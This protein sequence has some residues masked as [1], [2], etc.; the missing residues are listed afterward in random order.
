MP[1][2]SLGY[3]EK[4][5]AQDCAGLG[6]V[7]SFYTRANAEVN[8][9][10]YCVTLNQPCKHEIGFLEPPAGLESVSLNPLDRN[11]ILVQEGG[12][13]IS[14]KSETMATGRISNCVAVALT[15]HATTYYFLGHIN[16]ENIKAHDVDARKNFQSSKPYHPFISLAEFIKNNPEAN[17]ATLVS[18][19]AANLA[20]IKAVLRDMGIQ[21][22]QVLH[23]SRWSMDV[24]VPSIVD[25]GNL[26]IHQGKPCLVTDPRTF[27]ALFKPLPAHMKQVPTSLRNDHAPTALTFSH[28]AFK[29]ADTVSKQVAE[30]NEKTTYRHKK[31]ARLRSV[32]K[33][34]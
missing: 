23:Q 24:S 2:A 29:I 28:A 27:N 10:E 5:L 22:I 3:V 33:N 32:R 26:V 17:Q 19:N 25:Q 15:G 30:R 12:Y 34:R 8:A 7:T 21:E 20:Y 14:T 18:G 1:L 4:T 31:Q 11:V 6:L 16:G 9:A 13:G